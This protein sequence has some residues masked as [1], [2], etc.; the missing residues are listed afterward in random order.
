[1]YKSNAFWFS[2][3][4]DAR[5]CLRKYKLKH[6]DKL[7]TEEGKKGDLEFG[8]AMHLGVEMYLRGEDGLAIFRLYWDSIKDEKV[9]YGRYG[10]GP[11]LEMGV[12]LLPRFKKLHSKLFKPFKLEERIETTL[13]GI[14]FEGTPDFLGEYDGVPSVIDFKTSGARYEKLRLECDEQMPGYAAMAKEAYGYEA[15]QQVYIIFVKSDRAPSIQTLVSPLTSSKLFSTI[16]NMTETC[17][18]LQNRT[19]FPKNPLS[20][21]RGPMVCPYFKICNG[22]SE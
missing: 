7:S 10:W 2:K 15:T 3:I 11:L 21:L 6:I 5:T 14:G 8:T 22:G 9:E 19:V 16:L 17:S 4:S 12:E 1:M 18:D 20:C 13:G